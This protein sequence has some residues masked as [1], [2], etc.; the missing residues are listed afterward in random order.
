M[1]LKK[2]FPKEPLNEIGHLIP[3]SLNSK[4]DLIL[5]K[6]PFVVDFEFD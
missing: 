5:K 6:L 2:G 1:F 3:H 4:Y